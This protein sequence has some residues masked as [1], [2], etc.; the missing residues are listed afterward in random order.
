MVAL[1]ASLLETRLIL[2]PVRRSDDSREEDRGT[3]ALDSSLQGLLETR[4]IFLDFFCSVLCS[5]LFFNLFF[6]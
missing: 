1:D 3:A 2:C 4:Q 5:F 6:N